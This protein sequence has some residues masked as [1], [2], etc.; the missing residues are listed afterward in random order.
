MKRHLSHKKVIFVLG[1]KVIFCRLDVPW[2]PAS[3]P[4]TLAE[5]LLIYPPAWQRQMFF[6]QNL[7]ILWK[8]EALLFALNVK[9]NSRGN[10]FGLLKLP[11]IGRRVQ[12]IITILKFE[13]IEIFTS[14]SNSCKLIT[15][16]Q[17]IH[18]NSIKCKIIHHFATPTVRKNI[19]TKLDIIS[20]ESVIL[21]D[22]VFFH[23]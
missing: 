22:L 2:V 11:K 13:P 12:Y 3:F 7:I 21:S 15:Q 14:Y 1:E 4:L 20:S 6:F 16:I 9:T 10:L 23:E 19:E 8:G 5:V 18:L 17:L